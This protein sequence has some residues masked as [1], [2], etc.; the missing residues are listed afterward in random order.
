MSG[1]REKIDACFKSLN[2]EY[3]CLLPY[4]ACKEINSSIIQRENFIPQSAIVFLLPY[5]A[6]KSENMSVYSA[7]KDYH[8]I[9]KEVTD[10]LIAKLKEAFPDGKYK[11]YGDHSPINE[12]HAA[13]I[14][15]LGII[16]D[17]GLI[18]NEKYG[19][20][21]FVADVLTDLS[22]SVIEADEPKEIKGCS[23]CGACKRACPTR[24]LSGEGGDCLSAIT[25]RKGELCESEIALMRKYNTVWGCDV[26]QRVCPYNKEPK[27]TP[28]Q[29]FHDDRIPLLTSD[30]LA[31]MDKEEFTKRAF[32]WRGR[33][34]VERN[35]KH[36]G[37]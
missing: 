21:V 19:S 31:S 26:C 30:I 36:L 28:I 23:H 24:I 25:Q 35:L 15:G 8:I 3:Y 16:G 33:K 2:I 9:I 22:P 6:G 10:T 27:T 1:I 14:G 34:T 20:Y 17:M 13:L 37:Y 11:G 18:I 5:Y 4:S 7:S 12:C 29:F 32:A